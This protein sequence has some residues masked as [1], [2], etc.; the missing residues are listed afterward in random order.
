MAFIDETR[1]FAVFTVGS[2]VEGEEVLSRVFVQHL[3]PLPD[4]WKGKRGWATFW[5]RGSNPFAIPFQS[6][7]P[8][9][10]RP[11]SGRC[12][13]PLAPTSLFR[14]HENASVFTVCGTGCLFIG[15][16]SIFYVIEEIVIWGSLPKVTIFLNLASVSSVFTKTSV[17]TVL[18]PAQWVL[19][20]TFF[21]MYFRSFYL[22]FW[23]SNLIRIKMFLFYLCVI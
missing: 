23:F 11:L 17:F 2:K 5:L 9:M 1:Q 19:S 20:H 18:S 21:I 16:C 7:G 22:D 6:V 12:R 3:S 4:K 10:S 14:S 13:Q 8:L 15:F